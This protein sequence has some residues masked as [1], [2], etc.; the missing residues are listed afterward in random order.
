MRVG[1]IGSE[2]PAVVDA[3]GLIR[4]L[5]GLIPDINPSEIGAGL[6]HRMNDVDIASLPIIDADIRIGSCVGSV[7]RFFCIGLNYSDHAKESSLPIPDFPIVFMK[8]CETTGP[9]DPIVK[10]RNSEKLDWEVELGVVIG[11]EAK[12]VSEQDALTYVAG[13]CV[14]ND[15]SERSFQNEYGGQWVKGK[16]CDSFGPIGPYFVTADEVSDPQALKLHLMVN[17][18]LRQA[19]S[20]STMIFSVAKIISHLS[21]FI[22]LKPGDCPSS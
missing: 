6:V 5:S 18:K 17:G 12:H 22:T 10:P 19:G 21:E 3:D 4:D 2:K 1:P 16:S 15:V 20:T 11:R 14:V 13:Y 8:V 9:N 7:N